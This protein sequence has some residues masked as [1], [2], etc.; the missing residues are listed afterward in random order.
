MFADFGFETLTAPQAA[1]WFGLLLGL[2]FGALAQITRFCLR[3]AVAG[4]VEDRSEA[5]GTWAMALAV[6]ILGTQGAAATGLI[7]LSA[8]RFLSPDLPVVAIILGG[9]MFGAGMVLTRGCASRLTV[10]AAS[11]NLR[12]AL[13]LLTFAVAAHAALKGVLAPARLAVTEVSVALPVSAVP[14]GVLTAAVL[15]LAVLAIALTSNAPLTRL[16]GGAGIGALVPIAWI[17]TGFVLYDDFDPIAMQ[18]L[19][20]TAPW[21]D[22]LF[23][24]VASTAVPATFGAA[25]IAGTLVGAGASAVL[26]GETSWQSFESPAQT[27]RY[28][29]GG[30]LMG[31]GGVLA[32][33]CTI[34]AGLSGVPTLSVA[35]I[36][37]LASIIL[38]A[39]LAASQALTI[40]PGSRIAA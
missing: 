14:G 16:I 32:G 27:G 22:A 38:G 8:H 13:V 21:A 35:A 7:D 29:A 18:S 3:R 25:L 30:A 12:A 28:L 34:G 9:L 39:R 5:R 17:G 2:A 11:G 33:G 40:R 24:T 6:A 37:A 19:A 10:L 15:A 26:R 1:V 23:F 31:L 4:E 20:F 36:L